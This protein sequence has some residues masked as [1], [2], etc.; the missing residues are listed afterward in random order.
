VKKTT[1]SVEAHLG[2][3]DLLAVAVAS[4]VL[5]LGLG[6]GRQCGRGLLWEQLKWLKIGLEISAEGN[7]AAEGET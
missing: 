5:A 1:D 2:V 4:G 7:S 6:Q 3:L